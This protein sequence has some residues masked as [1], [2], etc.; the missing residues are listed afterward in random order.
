MRAI[1]WFRNDLRLADNP[2]LN[3]ASENDVLPIFIH[4]TDDA[5]D[6]GEASKVWL[7]H[8]LEKL[9]HSLGGKLH[10]IKGNTKR[11]YCFT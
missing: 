10:F 4:D 7:H 3:A 6:L 1:H 8:S 9:N 5:E 2:A 11:P